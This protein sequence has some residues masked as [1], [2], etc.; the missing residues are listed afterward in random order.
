MEPI[1]GLRKIEL[2]C[3]GRV[4]DVIRFLGQEEYFDY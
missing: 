2:I 3:A 4:I 1:C